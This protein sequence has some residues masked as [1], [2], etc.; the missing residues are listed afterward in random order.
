[1]CVHARV[2]VMAC[3]YLFSL[4]L[5]PSLCLPLS[6]SVPP[7]SLSLP[8]SLSPSLSLPLSLSLCQMI[9]FR[10]SAM[11]KGHIKLISQMP[12]FD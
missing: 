7:L 4:S 9:S 5:S 3:V 12:P 11:I 10:C 1:M 6:L 2:S 8:L